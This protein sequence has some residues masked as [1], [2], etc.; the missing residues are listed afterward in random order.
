M[1]IEALV[2]L[3]YQG[4]IQELSMQ[5]NEDLRKVDSDGRSLLIHAILSESVNITLIEILLQHGIDPNIKD[6]GQEWTALHFA[7]RDQKSQVVDL[8]LSHGADPNSIDI[9]GNTPLCRAIMSPKMNI[10]VI[11]KLLAAGAKPTIKNAQGNSPYDIAKML[12][13]NE[14]V[15]IMTRP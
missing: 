9:F 11:Q 5:S 1:T 4:N 6:K 10:D 3:V 7:A 15:E 2:N 14:I 8:L 13:K 12:R